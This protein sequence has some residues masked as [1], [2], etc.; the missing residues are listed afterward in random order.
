M[1]SLIPPN[2]NNNN[3]KALSQTQVL[4]N[5]HTQILH[6]LI[7]FSFIFFTKNNETVVQFTTTKFVSVPLNG[8]CNCNWNY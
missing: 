7:F 8:K 3:N 6:T 2:N 5:S 4:I 1:H